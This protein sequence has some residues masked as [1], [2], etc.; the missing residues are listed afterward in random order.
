MFYSISGDLFLLSNV[1]FNS[2]YEHVINFS[3][4][5]AQHDYFDEKIIYREGSYTHIKKDESV[6]VARN[7]ESLYDT[8]YVMYRNYDNTRWI[9][10]FITDKRYINEGATDLTIETDVFQTFMFDYTWHE[11]FIEREHADRWI[12]AGAPNYS[13]TDEG[14]TLGDEYIK[15]YEQ[16]IE[17][18]A[19]FYLVISSNQLETPDS[20]A[21]PNMVQFYPTPLYYY[22]LQNDANAAVMLSNEP[23]IISISLLPFLPF[24]WATLPAITYTD[25]DTS[26]NCTLYKI[27]ENMA[28]SKVLGSCQAFAGKTLPQTFAVGVARDYNRESK[29]LCYPYCFNKLTQYQG[30]ELLIKNEYLASQTIEV[31]MVQNISHDLKSKFFIS[32]GYKGENTGRENC[33]INNTINDLPLVT[34]YYKNY[35]QQHKA[36]IMTGY[37]VAGIGAAGAVAGAALTGGLSIPLAAGVAG[38]S[39]TGIAG[40]LAKQQDL[41][42]TP[43]AIRQMGN[44]I[45]FDI[46]DNNLNV[47]IVRM[48]VSEKIKKMLGDYF[49]MYGYKCREVKLPNLDTRYYYNFIKVIGAN[50]TGNIE[51]ADMVKLKGIFEKGVTI[52]HDRAGV[53]PL[54]YYY[55]NVEMELIN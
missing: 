36:S 50:I 38:Q 5:T 32:S 29:L 40:E 30:S 10:A 37:A 25:P 14:L 19:N 15:E 20:Y 42:T 21:A 27:D 49:A 1:F 9:Y 45:A 8:N 52:W 34:D 12:T 13:Y 16:L 43:D 23:A 31:K 7:I 26:L 54:S 18:T 47:K 4:P 2:D 33:L 17:S 48:S 53:V 35:M 41:K 55:D 28:T 24:E 44:N 6:R 3:D 46:A 11:S 51:Q 22:L 39:L